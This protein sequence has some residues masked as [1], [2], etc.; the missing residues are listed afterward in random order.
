[1]INAMAVQ[2]RIKPGLTLDTATQS[3]N[4]IDECFPAGLQ[5]AAMQGAHFFIGH[6]AKR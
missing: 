2:P 1:M 4:G 5:P 3:T 6:F